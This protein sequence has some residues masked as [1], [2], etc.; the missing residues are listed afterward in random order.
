MAASRRGNRR[1]KT[2]HD[3]WAGAGAGAGQPPQAIK[4]KSISSTRKY[5]VINY[6][7]AIALGS[8]I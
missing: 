5:F 1:K 4:F 8:R 7:R 6:G 2:G 3:V